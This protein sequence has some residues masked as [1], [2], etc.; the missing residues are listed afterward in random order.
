MPDNLDFA[1]GLTPQ[2]ALRDLPLLSPP[3]SAW[4]ALQATLDA[5][6]KP[7]RPTHMD[8]GSGCALPTVAGRR[9]ERLRPRWHWL[10][11]AAMLAFA[12]ALPRWL[13]TPPA[14]VPAVAMVLAAS[15][16]PDEATALRALMAESAQLEAL[17]AW[18]RAEPAES[19]VADGLAAAVQD[20]IEHVDALL[21]RADADPE[22]ALPLWQ[23]RVLRLRQL[24]G[25][26][27]TQQL[28][29]AN[30]DADRG[31]PVMAF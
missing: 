15:A 1:T 20:R 12:A 13:A 24:A 18:S 10:A 2:E 28:L 21:A 19:A 25:L 8:V 5:R 14:P 27:S 30:G 26:E 7:A 9:M 23:E 6:A 31:M 29:A 4:P 16:K 22:A 3:R 11:A 17:I